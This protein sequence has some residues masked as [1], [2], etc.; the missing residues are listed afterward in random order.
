MAILDHFA[1][2]THQREG[3]ISDCAR[4]RYVRYDIHVY[5]HM[6]LENIGLIVP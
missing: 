3:S 6:A 5:V 4:R 1:G 2:R